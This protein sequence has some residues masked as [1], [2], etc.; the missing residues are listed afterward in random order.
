[1]GNLDTERGTSYAFFKFCFT[2]FICIGSLFL[3]VIS[4]VFRPQLGISGWSASVWCFIACLVSLLW[5]ID[6]GKNHMRKDPVDL[7]GSTTT[8]DVPMEDKQQQQQQQEQH[9][10]VEQEA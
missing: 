3:G 6:V 10:P 8:P 5:A 9:Q 7:P 4:L 2:V 1:M